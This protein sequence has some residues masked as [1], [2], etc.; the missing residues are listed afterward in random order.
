M[1]NVFISLFQAAVAQAGGDPAEAFS[2]PRP[3][4]QGEGLVTFG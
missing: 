2:F 1:Q 3:H 4:P